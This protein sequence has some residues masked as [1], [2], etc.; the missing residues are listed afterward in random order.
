MQQQPRAADCG[1]SQERGIATPPGA[2]E[3]PLQRWT[4]VNAK[5]AL[6]HLRVSVSLG[7]GPVL[8]EKAG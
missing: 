3:C 2:D 5:V 8:R 4:A 6:T 1:G 7:V